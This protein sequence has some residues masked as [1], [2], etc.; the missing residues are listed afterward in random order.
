M[1]TAD[2]SDVKNLSVNDI[3]CNKETIKNIETQWSVKS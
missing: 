1:K 2:F 3:H